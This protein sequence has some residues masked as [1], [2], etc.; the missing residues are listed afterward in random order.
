M[1]IALT[2]DLEQKIAQKAQALGTTPENFV[3]SKLQEEF[4]PIQQQQPFK[5]QDEWER[6]LQQASS[7]AGVALSDEAVSSEGI[8]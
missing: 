8:Y 5:P 4:A 7:P 2:S 6:Q 1:I 3:L